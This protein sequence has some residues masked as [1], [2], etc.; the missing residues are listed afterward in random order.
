[1]TTSEIEADG[2]AVMQGVREVSFYEWNRD[3]VRP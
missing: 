1:M 2:Q 3:E